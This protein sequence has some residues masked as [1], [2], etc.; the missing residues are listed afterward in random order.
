M[1]GLADAAILAGRRAVDLSGGF[2][3]MLGWH[4]MALG[5]CGRVEE[6]RDVLGRLHDL[7][8]EIYV[9]P[10]SYA[11][12]HLGLRDVDCVFEWLDRAVDAR[13]QFLMPIKTYVFL[14]PIRDDPRFAALLRKMKLDGAP[15]TA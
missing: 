8:R 10:S 14:D 5:S 3:F 9:P 2:P 13:D 11:W 1:R 15:S 6:A 4:G 7:A 12:V